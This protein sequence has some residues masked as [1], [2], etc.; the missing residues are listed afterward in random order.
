MEKRTNAL[1][2][3]RVLNRDVAEEF[4]PGY[5]VVQCTASGADVLLKDCSTYDLM[6]L[7]ANMRAALSELVKQIG[8]QSDKTQSEVLCTVATMHASSPRIRTL[9]KINYVDLGVRYGR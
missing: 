5:A 6:C 4:E 1:F 8:K 3:T 7:A 2:P 9:R